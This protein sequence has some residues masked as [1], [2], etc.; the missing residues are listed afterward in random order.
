MRNKLLIISALLLFV[1]CILILNTFSIAN[2]QNRQFSRSISLSFID[3]VPPPPPPGGGSGGGGG[4]GG[5][6]G[7]VW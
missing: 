6:G 1:I 5:G 4:G 7:W 3:P 2:I